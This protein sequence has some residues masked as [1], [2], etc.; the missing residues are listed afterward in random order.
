MRARL[1]ERLGFGV[2]ASVLV[3]GFLGS[4]GAAI[5]QER[6]QVASELTSGGVET[7]TVTARRKSENEQNV[8]ISLTAIGGDTLQANGI[9]NALKL[10][11]LVPSLQIVSFNA[12]NTNLSVRGLGANIGLANDGIESGVGVYVDGVFY[13][14][15]AQATFDLPDIASI[16]VLRGPQGTLYGKNTTAGAINITT[17]KPVSTFEAR[18]Q[19]SYGDYNYANAMGTVSGSLTDDET[20]QGLSLSLRH[21]SRRVHDQC[22]DGQQELRLS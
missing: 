17:E 4:D 5:A 3:A 21:Q 7:V 22:H 1:K 9:T 2:A 10:T 19:V 20:L 16:E 18:G 6:T 13:P 15:P 14:R 12:R 8:P 11:E